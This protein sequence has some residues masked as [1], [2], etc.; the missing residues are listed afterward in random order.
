MHSTV[1]VDWM[2]DGAG[3]ALPGR[4]ARLPQLGRMIARI[5]SDARLRRDVGARKG[6]NL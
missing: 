6:V 2:L 4:C 1:R 5:A 3:R